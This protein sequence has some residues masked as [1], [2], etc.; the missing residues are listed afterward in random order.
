MAATV[1][2]TTD[3][4]IDVSDGTKPGWQTTEWLGTLITHCITLASMLLTVTGHHIDSHPWLAAVPAISFL[5]SAIVQ[6]IYTHSRARLKAATTAVAA[7]VLTQA[8]PNTVTGA[9][10][11]LLGA[12]SPPAPTEPS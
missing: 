1:P 9:A 10:G 7:A 4:S 8:Q 3:L 6:G 5:A 11:A 12:V 2:I